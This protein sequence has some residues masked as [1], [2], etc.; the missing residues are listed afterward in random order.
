MY[1]IMWPGKPDWPLWQRLLF[2]FFF[3]YFV[4]YISPWQWLEIIPGVNYVM[5]LYSKFI[6]WLVNSANKN[7]FHLYNNLV[8]LNGSGDTSWAFVQLRLFLLIALIST[9]VWGLLDR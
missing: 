2:R 1:Q 5:D 3:V 4:L 9:I 6:D 7:I 8:P